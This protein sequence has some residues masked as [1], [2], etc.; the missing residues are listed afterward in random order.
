VKAN[1]NLTDLLVRWDMIVYDANISESFALTLPQDVL[2]FAAE[3][4]SQE[5]FVGAMQQVLGDKWSPL[6]PEQYTSVLTQRFDT[7]HHW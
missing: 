7:C 3:N 5:K 4:S 6:S 2:T 1:P